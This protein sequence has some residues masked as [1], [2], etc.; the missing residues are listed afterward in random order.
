MALTITH[1]EDNGGYLEGV[2]FGQAIMIGLGKR[3]WL[4]PNVTFN[5]EVLNQAGQVQIPV[6]KPGTLK[7]ATPLCEEGVFNKATKEF[8]TLLLDSKINGEF[9][10][11]FSVAGIVPKDWERSL[12]NATLMQMAMDYQ[13]Q[14]ESK[15]MA[16]GTITSV[17]PTGLSPSALLLAMRSEFFTRNKQN[18]TVA[19]VSPVFYNSILKEQTNLG[20][21]G[22]DFAFINGAVGTVS[23]LVIV[24]SSMTTDVVLINEQS[25][26]IASAGS[27]AQIPGMDKITGDVDMSSFDIGF[28]TGMISKVDKKP[29]FIGISTYIHVPFGV[30]VINELVS[31]YTATPTP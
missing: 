31:K 23:G 11:C 21:A 15:L 29:T 8:R 28:N 17:D 3:A 22:S 19:L 5:Q 30:L 25:I 18:A 1:R 4:V 6:Y 26:H 14:V 20:T 2:T 9:D 27:V 13:I 10:D 24:E 16:G 12:N 7:G